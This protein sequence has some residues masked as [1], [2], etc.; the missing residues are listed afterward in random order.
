MPNPRIHEEYLGGISK[1]TYSVAEHG[2]A[3]GRIA[4]PLTLP[5]NT[6][7]LAAYA[8][9]ALNDQGLFEAVESGGAATYQLSIES[10]GDLASGAAIA[11]LN[12]YQPYPPTVAIP[13]V[14]TA[15]RQLVLDIQ[16][17]DLT[18]GMVDFYIEY[19]LGVELAGDPEPPLGG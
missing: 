1:I 10:E 17:A 9:P 7:I 12:T 6:I 13:I 19:R 18:Q 11:E 14:L 3:V 16:V 5:N 15:K 2:G 4:L 8:N